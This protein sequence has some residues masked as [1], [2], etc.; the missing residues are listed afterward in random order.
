MPEVVET[1]NHPS[2][3]A[4]VLSMTTLKHDAESLTVV[5]S[6]D[7]STTAFSHDAEPIAVTPVDSQKKST[8]VF[9]HGKII[10]VIVIYNYI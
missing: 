6:Q 9:S 5:D 8:T 4:H 10:I 2:E 7:K 1:L 3:S